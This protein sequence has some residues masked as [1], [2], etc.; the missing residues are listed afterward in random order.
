MWQ[1]FRH[2]LHLYPRLN[3]YK[4]VWVIEDDVDLF[5]DNR[6]VLMSAVENADIEFPEVDL[7][8]FSFSPTKDIKK[9]C[10]GWGYKKH[11]PGYE[12]ILLD[13]EQRSLS[14]FCLS[15]SI[16]RLSHRMIKAHENALDSAQ[17]MW[18][19]YML[20]PLALSKNLSFHDLKAACHEQGLAPKPKIAEDQ[21]R[22]K[23]ISQPNNTMCLH[24]L[25][26]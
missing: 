14:T 17:I 4:H 23:S 16:Q 9:N 11:T 3:A 12:Q 15:D 22:N 19:E 10:R 26:R 1:L 18:A 20:H 7:L 13:I 8:G 5:R 6:S 24:L 25:Q 2:P 21:A